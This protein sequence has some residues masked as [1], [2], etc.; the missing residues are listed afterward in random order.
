MVE[1]MKPVL[2]RLSINLFS[3]ALPTLFFLTNCGCSPVNPQQRYNQQS[4]NPPIGSAQLPVYT[5]G[6]TFVFSDGS[7]ERV[8]EANPS[9][10]IW[11]NNLGESSLAS[12]DFTY[13]P[14]KWES[15]SVKGY[16]SFEPTEYLYSVSNAS[17][18]PLAVGNTTHY[19][20]KNKWGVPGIYEKHTNATWRCTVSG[21]EQVNVPAG[22]FATWEI[23]CSRYSRSL[24]RSTLTLWEKKTFNYSPA[25]GHWVVV[26]QD[27]KNGQPKI[28][29]ELVAI[30]PSLTSLGIDTKS[31]IGIKEHF[32]QTL[33]TSASGQME[34][35]SNP[36]KQIS[37][38]MTP[39][40]TYKLADGTP[41][42]QYEQKLDLNSYSKSY[43]GIACRSETGMW[44]VPRK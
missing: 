26:E 18:W 2:R 39:I 27:F 13:R 10:V 31:S 30:L 20:E 8:T 37:F 42:R 15:K 24:N 9:F 3:L 11:E 34:R 32:Q 17:L 35:W 4:S 25:V 44:T 19:E 41:C 28:R 29:K 23:T 21:T 5:A 7:W 6:T 43:Y 1:I 16:R 38:S 12:T 22:S 36:D 14:V 33:G 40:A